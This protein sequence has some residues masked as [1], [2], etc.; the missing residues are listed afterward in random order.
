MAKPLPQSVRCLGWASFFTDLASEMMAPLIPLF[1]TTVLGA[2]LQIV[3]IYEGV[4][5]G[6]ANGAKYFFGKM[7]D[8][9]PRLTK[10]FVAAGYA[11]ANGLRPFIGL[12]PNAGVAMAIRFT[13]RVGKGLRSPARDKWLSLAAKGERGRIFGH[14]RAMDHAGAA[15]G[16]VVATI[17]LLI[18]PEHL[19][20]LFLVTIVPGLIAVIF[21]VMARR[22]EESETKLP[23]KNEENAGEILLKRTLKNEP[24]TALNKRNFRRYLLCLFIFTLGN[25]SDAFILVAL[26]RCGLAVAFLPAAWFAFH[27]VKSGGSKIFGRLADRVGKRVLITY[28]W[29]LYVVIYGLFATNT[30]LYV[31]LPAFMGYGIFYALTE[32]SEKAMIADIVP[33]K[34]RGQAYG[35]V[36]LFGGIAAL[37]A[38]LIAG[39]IGDRFGLGSAFG[40]GA[41]CAGAGL[42]LMKTLLPARLEAAHGGA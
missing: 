18:W 12:A 31:L 16:P 9:F 14:Q 3:G 29:A 20:E 34:E 8:R 32:S 2:N 6:I 27:V 10:T 22:E 13:D 17:F 28:G 25:S 7:A 4:S 15:V 5:D 26:Q 11:L 39:G 36:S 37:L 40:F 1:L 30:S 38:S 21:V 33:E 41:A 42:I 35:V 23:L 24:A 19:R